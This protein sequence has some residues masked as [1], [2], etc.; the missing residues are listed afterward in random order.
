MVQEPFKA[1]GTLLMVVV[2]VLGTVQLPLS[3][4]GILL[5]VVV[6]LLGGLHGVPSIKQLVPFTI[7]C[8]QLVPFV[9]Q[10]VPSKLGLMA[11]VSFPALVLV[12]LMLELLRRF[13]IS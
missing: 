11:N 3:A 12:T 6:P 2:P 8:P 13:K 5:I 7:A 9:R 1:Q 10:K 4:H